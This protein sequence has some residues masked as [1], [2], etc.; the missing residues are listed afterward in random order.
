MDDSVEIYRLLEADFQKMGLHRPMRIERYEAGTELSYTVTGVDK[1]VSA[2]VRL[3]IEKFIGGGFAGQ[4]YRV[5]V[6]EINSEPGFDTKIQVGGV[7]A[8]KILIP[9][10]GFSRLFRNALYWLGFQGPF[11][12]QVN[13]SAAR[14]GALWQKFIRRG[15]DIALGDQNAVV[16]IYATFVDENLGS[17]GEL[18][19]WVQ[20]RTWRLEVDDHLGSLKRWIKGKPVDPEKLGSPEYRAKYTFM[21]EFVELLHQM[22]AHEFAR[23]YEWSTWKSQPN[24][25]KRSDTENDPAGGLTAVD[26]RAGLALLPFLPMSPGDFKLILSGL[27]RGSLVQFDRGDLAKLKQYIADHQRE[28]AGTEGMLN[29]LE[30]AEAVYRNSIPDMTHHHVRL[31]YSPRLWGAILKSAVTGWKVRNLIDERCRQNLQNN[32]LSTL[33][34]ALL[35][36]VPI[37]GRFF[38]RIWGQPFWRRHY[39]NMLT[40]GSYFKKA[41][42][43]KFIERLISWHRDDR[44]SDHTVSK[45]NRQIWRC[46]YHMPI[47][48]LPAG[49]HRILT[50]WQHAKE[51][52]DYYLLRPVRLYFKNELREQWLRDM[53]AEG[54]EKHLLNDDDAAV[55]LSQIK[56]PYIQKYLKLSLIH[57]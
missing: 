25:L 48:V 57:I 1:P 11:Q 46:A 27:L 5:R 21:Q 22:G 23:Q 49:L 37:I 44:V 2:D 35:G 51:R 36:L 43:A 38:R 31:L 8:V 26:F 56:E 39:R 24:C 32:K 41:L 45:L 14:A 50:D 7:Y 30:G 53:V 52:L 40:S 18:S 54:K 29:E 15:A 3:V 42:R 16:D 12:L 33:L 47:S 10:S 13:P 9:P 6:L 28:F 19:E 4:V 55:I 17:C 34:F 20:G